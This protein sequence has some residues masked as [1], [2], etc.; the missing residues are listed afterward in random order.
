MMRFSLSWLMSLGVSLCVF[1][2]QAAVEGDQKE[3]HISFEQAENEVLMQFRQ[4]LPRLQAKTK[5]IAIYE[6]TATGALPPGFTDS[7]RNKL[8]R[9]ILNGQ[10][11]QI[12][13]CPQCQTSRLVKDSEGKLRYESMSEEVGRV[14]KIASELGVQD[15]LYADVSSSAEDLNLKVRLVSAS[16]QQI[17]W[18]GE[19]STAQMVSQKQK[20]VQREFGTEEIGT[21]DSLNRMLIGE[22]A[23]TMAL[24]PGIMMVPTIDE[25]RGN[26]RLFYPSVDLFIGEKF[27]QGHKRFGFL[28]G[29]AFSAIEGETAGKPAPYL[30]RV[31]PQFRYTFNPH[32]TTTARWSVVT[33]AGGMISSGLATFY[34]SAGPEIMMV[35]RFSVSVMPMYI[36]PT[37]VKGGTRIVQQNGNTT[38]NAGNDQGRFGGMGVLFKGTWTW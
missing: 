30:I 38:T 3:L 15:V 27:D 19:Y 33:E 5:K 6:V 29:G 23:F 37:N 11:V 31:A 26:E 2:A 18:S 16:D 34:A 24:S 9:V 14:A 13:H 12:I 8:E 1:T 35:R 22:I 7:F 21:G 20:L 36:L 32:N 25:G 10:S 28:F 4:E 17:H